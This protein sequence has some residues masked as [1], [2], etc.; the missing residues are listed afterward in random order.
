[1]RIK[2]RHWVSSWA[3]HPTALHCPVLALPTLPSPPTSRKGEERRQEKGKEGAEREQER[4]GGWRGANLPRRGYG[5]LRKFMDNKSRGFD[6][7]KKPKKKGKEGFKRE[8][9][10]IRMPVGKGGEKMIPPPLS[11]LLF[12]IPSP[13]TRYLAHHI[14]TPQGR[15]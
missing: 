15:L 9:L 3:F 1:M 13:H 6:P 14:W 11:L 7:A 4:W 10:I 8:I 2:E 12:P 5:L